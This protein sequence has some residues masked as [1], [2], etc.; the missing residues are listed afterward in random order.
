MVNSNE[1]KSKS[2]RNLELTTIVDPNRLVHYTYQHQRRFYK[3]DQL[4]QTK[5]QQVTKHCHNHLNQMINEEIG[6]SKYLFNDNGQ[7]IKQ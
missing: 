5:V 7:I 3:T 4:F 1:I 2:Y 6:Y